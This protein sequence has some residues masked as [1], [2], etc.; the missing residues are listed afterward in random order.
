MAIGDDQQGEKNLAAAVLRTLAYFDVFDYP[1]T[2]LEVQRWLW[3]KR[4]SA[5]EVVQVLQQLEQAR[6]LQRVH[7]YYHLPGRS[8]AVAARW[9]RYLDAELKFR[10]ALRAAGWLRWLPA[11]R[12]VAVCNN[13]AYGNAKTESDIDL[14]IVVAPGRLWL[15]RLAVT[16][17]MQLLGLRRH[18]GRIAN[19][20]CLSFYVTANAADLSR[21]SLAPDDPYL[22][23]WLATLAVIYARAGEAESFWHANAWV[24][25]WLPNGQPRLLSARRSV[26]APQHWLLPEGSAGLEYIARRLQRA[27]MAT[28]ERARAS[29]LGVV[30]SDDV[31]KFHEEDRRTAYR[32][33]WEERCQAQ[34]V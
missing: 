13:A 28:R 10:R 3:R 18:G 22:V 1:L 25:E 16:V 26:P 8:A 20:C 23:Y 31:L 19:R 2:A 17:I 11:V 5:S 12:L 29:R 34:G 14:F 4:A 9:Q 33:Q 7:G 6:R 15:T 24:K 32:Q 21:F 27:K 30:I